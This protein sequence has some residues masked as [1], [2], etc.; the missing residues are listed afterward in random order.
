MTTFTPD[1]FQL[2]GHIQ[3]S[4]WP[5]GRTIWEIRFWGVYYAP[6]SLP[7]GDRGEVYVFGLN[8]DDAPDLA[9]RKRK[10]YTFG[11]RLYRP[12]SAGR[13]DYEI[14]SVFQAGESGGA[15]LNGSGPVRGFAGFTFDISGGTHA[16]WIDLE[17]DNLD[18]NGAGSVFVHGYGYETA[19]NTAIAAGVPE[20][21]SIAI[22][23]T[24]SLLLLRRRDRPA[25]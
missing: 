4:R 16:G 19:A 7:W 24:G 5:F 8:E 25:L 15:W 18:D 9:T 12:A 17:L 13:L 14:E 2:P 20:P 21:A 1:E 23:A 6:G 10:L 22:L 11:L 3:V